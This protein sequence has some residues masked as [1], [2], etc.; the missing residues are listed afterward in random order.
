VLVVGAAAFRQYGFEPGPFVADGTRV[1]VVTD[2]VDEAHRSAADLAVLASPR[3]V[4]VAL[5][6]VVRPRRGVR[7]VAAD[8]PPAQPEPPAPG[9]PMRASHVLAAIAERLPHDGVLV[10]ETPSS[11]SELNSRI[12]ARHPLG[13]VSAAMGGLGFAMP[14][15]VGIRM[16]L[17]GRPVVAVVGDGSSLYAIQALWSAQ[18]YEA[19]VLFVVL[20]NGGYAIMDRLARRQGGLGPWPAFAD[21]DMTALAT[22][23][24]CPAIRVDRHEQRRD[25]GRGRLRALTVGVTGQ[26]HSGTGLQSSRHPV[27]RTN[28]SDGCTLTDADSTRSSAPR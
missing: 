20:R 11:R 25:C 21:V 26:C 19:G 16:A 10:E 14:A 27:T 15:A 8:P 9:E 2:D 1:A 22:G 28:R 3:A 12:P 23:F 7:P 17:P 5:A 13:F 18:R 24:A 6:R 4:C